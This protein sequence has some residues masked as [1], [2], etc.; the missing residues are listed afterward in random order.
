MP[1]TVS[2][3]HIVNSEEISRVLAT[4]CGLPFEARRG[5]AVCL[6][7]HLLGAGGDRNVKET[8]GAVKEIVSSKEW[9]LMNDVAGKNDLMPKL[10][11]RTVLRSLF[12]SLGDEDGT[13]SKAMRSSWN[14]ISS[15]MRTMDIIASLSPVSGF[16]YSVREACKELIAH[17]PRYKNLIERN[18]DLEQTAETMK[19]MGSEMIGHVIDGERDVQ[20]KI[21][22]V[23]DTSKSMYGEPDMIARSLTLALTKQMMRHN[24]NVSVMLFSSGLPILSPSNGKDMME[25][26]SFAAG[27]GEQFAGALNM[28]LEKM[29]QKTLTDTDLILVSKGADIISDPNFTHDWESFRMSSNIKVI[30]AVAGGDSA[31]ALTEL[32]DHV[33]VFNDSTIH[34]EGKEFVKLIDALMS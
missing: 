28:L 33:A 4:P 16:S 29:K 14:T 6:A 11:L 2:L 24:G 26:I 12:D 3:E 23:I 18:D 9:M 25:M 15:L 8:S 32:S 1:P 34:N 20:R 30:T 22:V 21:L 17:A 27:S 10:I 13:V 19:F 31:R 5:T 7:E